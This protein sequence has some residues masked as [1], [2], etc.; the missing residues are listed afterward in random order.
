MIRMIPVLLLRGIGQVVLQGNAVSGLLMLAAILADSWQAGL[1]ALGGCL[2]GTLTACL[3]RCDEADIRQGLYGFNATLVGLAAAVF[4]RFSPA[5]LLVAALFAALSTPVT[6]LFFMQK[7]VPAFTAPFILC[8]WCMLALCAAFLPETLM[9]RAAA[10]PSAAPLDVIRAAGAG[11]GQ[12]MFRASTG[13]GLL[14]LMAILVNSWSAALYALLGLFVS[15]QVDDIHLD[16]V[17]VGL[18]NRGRIAV[19]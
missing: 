3:L 19:R 17:P 9:V 5:G 10:A 8:T 16:T 18:S 2:V 6:R 12:V 15:L 13:V 1:L 7:R 4:L 14:F 11:I